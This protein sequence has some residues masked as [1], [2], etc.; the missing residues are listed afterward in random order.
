ML[1]YYQAYSLMLHIFYL[2]TSPDTDVVVAG[3]QS[4]SRRHALVT[5]EE[6]GRIFVTD[7][8]SK[9]GTFVCQK[10]INGGVKIELHCGSTFTLGQGTSTFK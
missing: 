9:F 6:G 4:V 3:D 8:H 1:S 10:K 7:H 5:V 2:P